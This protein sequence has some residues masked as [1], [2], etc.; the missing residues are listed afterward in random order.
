MFAHMQDGAARYLLGKDGVNARGFLLGLIEDG[1]PN[2]M[3]KVELASDA[4]GETMWSKAIA[5]ID[6]VLRQIMI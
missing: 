4:G 5:S 1:C 2:P 3:T 6:R